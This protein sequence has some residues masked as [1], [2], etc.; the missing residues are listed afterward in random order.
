VKKTF[1]FI[2]FCISISAVY[3]QFSIQGRIVDY[4]NRRPLENVNI[5][6][7]AGKRVISD[8]LGNYSISVK[9]GDSIWFSYF[10][11]NTVKYPVDTITN[12]SN[13]E[14]GLHIEAIFLPP[15]TVR[16][17]SYKM[18]SI[19][20]RQDYAKAFN[21]K[22]PGIGLTPSYN[23]VPGGVTVG[24]DLDEFINMFRFKRNKRMLALQGRLLQQE[25]DKYIDHRFSKRFA[26]QLTKLESPELETFM[27]IYRPSYDFLQM[28]ND[29]EL[30]I[31]I[32][33]SFEDY[34]NRKA[35]GIF[36]RPLQLPAARE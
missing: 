8:T 29:L 17:N 28:V 25:E 18:D 7:S 1:L 33:K 22:K 27:A 31:Y 11:K 13:F 9:N 24:L 26:R 16:N 36:I 30:G 20:N 12:T 2:L 35:S 4:T 5:Y 14:V 34:K 21:F 15:V 32:Q 23:A 6:S 10:G 19:Q 3:S